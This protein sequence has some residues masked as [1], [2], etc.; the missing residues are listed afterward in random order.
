MTNFIKTQKQKL[1]KILMTVE[2]V[3]K[4]M[5]LKIK[6]SR[7]KRPKKFK[8]SHII[9]CFVYKVKNKINSFRE[10]EYKINEDEEFKK[11]IGIE[12]SF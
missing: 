2:K 4:A 9:A 12:K 5:G 7:S 6:S 10:L 8:L 1:L 3:I 11:A